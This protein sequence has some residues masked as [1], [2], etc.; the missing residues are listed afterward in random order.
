MAELTL[1]QKLVELQRTVRALQV[2]SENKGF[3]YRYISGSKVLSVVR[4]KMDELGLT[5]TQTVEPSSIQISGSSIFM[6][7]RFVW[8]DSASGE[9]LE[10]LWPS[11]GQNSSLDKAIGCAMTYGE[12]YFLMKQLH[13][14]TDEDDV[15]AQEPTKA[16]PRKAQVKGPKVYTMAGFNAGE[17]ADVIG[18]LSKHI[19]PA[20]QGLDTEAVKV[21]NKPCYQWEE[22]VLDMIVK[23]AKKK[24]FVDDLNGDH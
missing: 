13:I 21:V 16:E 17:Y 4:P 5:L 22:G 6:V 1:T 11:A 14:A 10:V 20:T 15:D 2:D 23:A 19:D 12:R 7:L 18:Y 9:R 8:T 24:A 3:K